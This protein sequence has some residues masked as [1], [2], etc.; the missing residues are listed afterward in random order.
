[1]DTPQDTDHLDIVIISKED[2]VFRM[3]EQGRWFNESG[4]ITKPSIVRYFNRS[5]GWDETGFF[6]TQVV[7][8]R[9]EKVYFP[10][11]ETALFAV[12][13]TIKSDRVAL[14][15]NTKADTELDPYKLFIKNDNLYMEFEGV[16]I[17]FSE[18]SLL[19]IAGFLK[20]ENGET[21]FDK[22]GSPVM[23]RSYEDN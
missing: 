20:E 22:E 1:M 21:F 8:N 6:V 12:D 16:F 11:E 23:I 17:R 3:D 10:F 15:L 9:L 2:A 7:D 5:L 19:K 13:L 14:H 18:R 4:R